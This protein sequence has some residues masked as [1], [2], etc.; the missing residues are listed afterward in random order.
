MQATFLMGSRLKIYNSEL[1]EISSISPFKNIKSTVR[2]HTPSYANIDEIESEH[3]DATHFD[4][5]VDSNDSLSKDGSFVMYF[6]SHMTA[7]EAK[8][9]FCFIKDNK[10]IDENL[11]VMEYEMMMYSND[12]KMGN[13]FNF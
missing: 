13:L 7:E 8:D 11:L 2:V 1:K 12:A 3:F 5:Y 6:P 10:L 9:S 4:D